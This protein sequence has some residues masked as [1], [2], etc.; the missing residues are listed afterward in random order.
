MTSPRP[1]EAERS[2][3]GLVIGM[4]V[5][6]VVSRGPTTDPSPQ[7]LPA[8]DGLA[9]IASWIADLVPPPIEATVISGS[10]RAS[11]GGRPSW[12]QT[13]P[14]PIP[15]ANPWTA[16]PRVSTESSSPHVPPALRPTY[17]PVHVITGATGG[18]RC[19][20]RQIRGDEAPVAPS[21]R[22]GDQQTDAFSSHLTSQNRFS[23]PSVVRT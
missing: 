21:A 2:N 4:L 20:N 19:F 13:I 14:S 7:R 9:Q 6:A 11:R 12:P 1:E 18:G 23:P 17:Q 3:R 8:P 22:Q 16:T 10:G 15:S 5:A